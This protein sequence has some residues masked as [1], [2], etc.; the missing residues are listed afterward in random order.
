MLRNAISRA[1]SC[2]FFFVENYTH[3]S[4]TQSTPKKGSN[5]RS[6]LLKMFLLRNLKKKVTECMNKKIFIPTRFLIY[7]KNKNQIQKKQSLQQN[8]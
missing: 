2:G 3:V 7:S 1:D 5:K 8:K 6:S 4:F